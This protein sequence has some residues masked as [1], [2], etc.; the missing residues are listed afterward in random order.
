M[1]V[2]TRHEELVYWYTQ[3]EDPNCIAVVELVTTIVDGD[4][5]VQVRINISY[6]SIA[7]SEWHMVS[8]SFQA[9]INNR[10]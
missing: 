8:I 1:E 6:I 9:F 10:I 2:A 7:R 3:Y 4:S 5:G